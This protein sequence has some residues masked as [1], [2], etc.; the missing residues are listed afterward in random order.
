MNLLEFVVNHP[1]L[2]FFCIVLISFFRFFTFFTPLSFTTIFSHLLFSS[3]LLFITSSIGLV[4]F[5]LFH[6]RFLPFFS[7]LIFLFSFLLLCF[8][9]LSKSSSVFIFHIAYLLS[10]SSSLLL[11][12]NFSFSLPSALIL[13]DLNVLSTYDFTALICTAIEENPPSANVLVPY[14]QKYTTPD[15]YYEKEEKKEI[16]LSKSPEEIQIAL[17]GM[18]SRGVKKVKRPKAH[19]QNPHENSEVHGPPGDYSK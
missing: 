15:E 1:S 7:A 13:R 5:H 3:F 12:L 18:N 11:L 8:I 9:H 17:S 19:R 10:F 16:L 14:R 2:P 4:F 6:L